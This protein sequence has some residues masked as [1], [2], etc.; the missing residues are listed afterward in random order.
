MGAGKENGSADDI[1]VQVERRL[2]GRGY[3]CY[4]ASQHREL[5]HTFICTPALVDL[6]TLGLVAG[7]RRVQYILTEMG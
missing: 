5:L 2:T 6:T 1:E 4:Q 3:C 7:G